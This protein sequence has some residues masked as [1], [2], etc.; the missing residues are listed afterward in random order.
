MGISRNSGA[1]GIA[2]W[3]TQKLGRT[4]DKN[5]PVVHRLHDW[6]NAQYES[7]RATNIGDGELWDIYEQMEAEKA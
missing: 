4:V 2:V 3:L 6:V 7:G 5:E 1:A